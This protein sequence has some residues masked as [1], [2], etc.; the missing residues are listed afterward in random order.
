MV[1]AKFTKKQLYAC[2]FP[3]TTV[4]GWYEGKTPGP[5]YIVKIKKLL[6]EADDRTSEGDT[7]RAGLQGPTDS[8]R[9][10]GIDGLDESNQG[11]VHAG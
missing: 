1:K 10:Q 8:R 2:G 4:R 3:R 7:L 9:V 6:E 11:T 5:Q